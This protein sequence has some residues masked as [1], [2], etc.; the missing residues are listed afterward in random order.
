MQIQHRRVAGLAAGISRPSGAAGRRFRLRALSAAAA[1]PTRVRYVKQPKEDK[2]FYWA[3]PLP[4][5]VDNATNLQPDDVAVR[6]TDLRTDNDISIKRNGF[7]LVRI[8]SGQ[9]INWEDA[10]QVQTLHC[11]TYVLAC[12]YHVMPFMLVCLGQRDI[13]P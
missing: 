4:T 13:L 1:A 8:S 3:M 2:L 6:L 10:D 12:D 11:Q 7:E 9:G 5:G